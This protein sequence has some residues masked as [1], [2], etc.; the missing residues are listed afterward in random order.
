L[1]RLVVELS[2]KAEEIVSIAA[3]LLS[4]LPKVS[5]CFESSYRQSI[6]P[7]MR[8]FIGDAKKCYQSLPRAFL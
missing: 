2:P 8:K 4:A 5:S 7:D 1:Q 6:Q 3:Q